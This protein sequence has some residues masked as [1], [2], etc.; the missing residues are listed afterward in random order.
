MY[1]YASTQLLL[2]AVARALVTGA[3]LLSLP[4][5]AACHQGCGEV[6]FCG[7]STVTLGQKLRLYLQVL[8]IGQ[9]FL[10]RRIFP[11]EFRHG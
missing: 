6:I 9:W 11:G 3:L 4:A 5:P 1:R 2:L 10:I 7:T 8:G